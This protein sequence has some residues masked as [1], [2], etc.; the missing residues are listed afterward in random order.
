MDDLPFILLLKAF[1][2]P[3]PE[4][5]PS[6]HIPTIQFNSCQVWDN[7]YG[8]LIKSTKKALVVGEW[9]GS[10]NNKDG[11]VQQKLAE[12]MI[13]NCFQSNFWYVSGAG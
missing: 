4:F 3:S 2:R 11:V 5:P 13:A 7:Q 12:W 8:W 6:P 9:G 10:C 1:F